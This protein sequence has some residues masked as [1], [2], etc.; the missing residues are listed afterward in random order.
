MDRQTELLQQYR[1]LPVGTML[2]CNS[3]NWFMDCHILDNITILS[4]ASLHYNKLD[5]SQKSNVTQK[6]TSTSFQREQI[7]QLSSRNNRHIQM[8]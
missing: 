4:L 5:A 1:A 7:P 3:D 6:D 2:T 8:A